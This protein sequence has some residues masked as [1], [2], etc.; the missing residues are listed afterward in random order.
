MS[1]DEE[2]ESLRV[3]P[4][5]ADAKQL[6]HLFEPSLFVRSTDNLA[7]QSRSQIG[8]SGLSTGPFRRAT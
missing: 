7:F 1:R 2:V 4:K 3:L 8:I 5:V 6:I